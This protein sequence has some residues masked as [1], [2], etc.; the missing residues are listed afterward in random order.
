MKL[1]IDQKCLDYNYGKIIKKGTPFTLA[2]GQRRTIKIYMPQHY[3]TVMIINIDG[4]YAEAT[5]DNKAPVY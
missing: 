4:E 3:Y 5:I 1:G 2:A